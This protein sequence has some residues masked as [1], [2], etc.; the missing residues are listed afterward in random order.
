MSSAAVDKILGPLNE[1]QRAAAQHVDGP[2]LI[3]A[4]PGS[5]KTR[6]ITH[7]IAYLFEQGVSSHNILALTFTNKAAEEMRNRLLQMVDDHHCWTG[8]FHKFCARLLRIHAPLIGLAE[9]FT[10]YDTAD[11][12]GVVRQAIE[13]VGID[14]RHHTPQSIIELI[15]K[16]KSRAIAPDQF[17][18]APGHAL[19]A[20]AA[21]VYPEYQKLLAMANAV[22]FDDLLLHCVD[23]LRQ[24]LEL[25]RS[26][27]LRYQYVLVDEYQDTNH[28]QYQL[29]RLLNHDLQNLAVTPISRFTVGAGQICTTSWSSKRISPK[30]K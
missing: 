25:R 2:L 21:R 30:S 18:P 7:R 3:L 16:I 29:I 14:L 19:Q 4:G 12:R 5:G 8:T 23:L 6:V 22:D 20:M 10:I 9:N 17:Q 13:N 24:N 1:A 27:D 11:S 26:L 15:S 28:A